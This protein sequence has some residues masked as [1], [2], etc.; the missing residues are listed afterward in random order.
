MIEKREEI[1]DLVTD[2]P[3]H[4]TLENGNHQPCELWNGHFCSLRNLQEDIKK[5]KLVDQILSKI[6]ADD[7]TVE[8]LS[9]EEIH[10]QI[11]YV[12]E[13]NNLPLEVM[14]K[15]LIE[16][17]LQAQASKMIEGDGKTKWVKTKI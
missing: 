13:H 16:S 1:F 12:G 2:P 17:C 11:Q 10:Y 15:P 8:L 3:C 4:Y 9:W 14:L 7:Q 6:F 5:C